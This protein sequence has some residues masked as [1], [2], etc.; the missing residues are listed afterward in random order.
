[1]M[2]GHAEIPYTGC[3][4]AT[5]LYY[6]V[7]IKLLIIIISFSVDL[8]TLSGTILTGDYYIIGCTSV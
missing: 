8:I 1:M 5:I 2:N 7:I 4:F 3:I 6:I